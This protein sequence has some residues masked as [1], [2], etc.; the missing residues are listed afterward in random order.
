MVA[1]SCSPQ[2]YVTIFV[3]RSLKPAELDLGDF[4]IYQ[5]INISMNEWAAVIKFEQQVQLLRRNPLDTLSQVL[6]SSLLRI[7]V[8]LKNL[9]ISS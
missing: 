7:H 4:D 3:E 8:T 2:K 5:Y 9:H 1:L 6:V